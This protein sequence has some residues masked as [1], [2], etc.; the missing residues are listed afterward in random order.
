MWWHFSQIQYNTLLHLSFSIILYK[1]IRDCDDWFGWKNNEWPANWFCKSNLVCSNV[2]DWCEGNVLRWFIFIAKDSS[3]NK[4]YDKNPA[5]KYYKKHS[6]KEIN[7]IIFEVLQR[8]QTVRLSLTN[9]SNIRS[10]CAQSEY[11]LCTCIGDSQRS[12]SIWWLPRSKSWKAML[13]QT[14]VTN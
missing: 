4:T 6:M 3:C 12:Y 8:L 9:K 2:T 10:R 5:C 1:K 13:A 7:L 14:W 11:H